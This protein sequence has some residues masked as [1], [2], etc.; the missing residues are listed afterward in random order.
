MRMV[1]EIIFRVLMAAPFGLLTFAI[2]KT[3]INT[4]SFEYA[5][6]WVALSMMPFFYILL[7]ESDT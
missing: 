2:V 7:M 3:S 4:A 5:S 6:I 1:S